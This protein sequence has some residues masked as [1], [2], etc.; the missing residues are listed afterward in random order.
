MSSNCETEMRVKQTSKTYMEIK[1]DNLNS[2]QLH[3]ENL[4]NSDVN[5]CPENNYC[6]FEVSFSEVIPE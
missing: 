6:D 1:F 2:H 3:K 5:E 4:Q